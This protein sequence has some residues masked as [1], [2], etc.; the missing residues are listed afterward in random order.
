[1]IMLVTADEVKARQGLNENLLGVNDT[2]E[3]MVIGAQLRSE[4]E[5]GSVFDK[6]ARADTFLL[7]ESMHGGVQPDGYFR[8]RLKQA[9]LRADPAP[10]Y[11]VGDTVAAGESVDG[12]VVDAVRGV[13]YVPKS[14][15]GSYFKFEYTAGFEDPEEAPVWLKEVILSIVPLISQQSMPTN[16]VKEAV[17]VRKEVVDHVNGLLL[18]Q[19]RSIGFLLKPVF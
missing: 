13:V 15:A 7:D 4:V 9:F 19:K 18:A 6:Q 11:S 2:I 8:C 17:D 10:V 1:M 14:Y 16:R 3:S 12:V 5:Y